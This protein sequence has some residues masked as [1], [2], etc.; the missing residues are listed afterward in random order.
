MF[1]EDYDFDEEEYEKERKL[2]KDRI[3]NLPIVIK[4]KDMITTIRGFL[5]SVEN[6]EDKLDLKSQL[7]GDIAIINAKIA[8]AEAMDYYSGKMENAVLIKIHAMSILTSTHAFEMMEIGNAEY[9]DLI[10]A[11]VESFRELFVAWKST[12]DRNND[13]PDDWGLF[14]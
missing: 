7:M 5:A 4:A 8:G 11:E 2:E 6:D 9:L 12:F 1:D 10:R 14:N 3:A 13:F